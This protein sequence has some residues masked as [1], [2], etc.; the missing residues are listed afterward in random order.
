MA[1]KTDGP[2][3]TGK[4]GGR[5]QDA[6]RPA[7]AMTRREAMLQL[8]RLGGVAA[9]AAGAGVWLSEHSRRPVAGQAEQ[10][11]RDHRVASERAV[12]ADDRD[13]ECRAACAGGEGARK[14]GRD[15]PVCQ[16]A[17][18][19]GAEAEHRVG[20]HAGAGGQH[21]S[22]T[23]RG[24]GTAVL[25]SRSQ[26]RDRHRRELQRAAPLLPALRASRRR[27]APRAPRSFCPIRSIS[28]RWI[29]AAWC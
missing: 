17:G 26:A 11:R 19:G 27:R 12:A 18:R 21:Q 10:A 22:R 13:S 1:G 5:K 25:A 28:A 2:G 4:P 9:G 7:P 8:L 6:A 3:E 23:G 14:S 16:P 29:W 15:E 24:G 20:P